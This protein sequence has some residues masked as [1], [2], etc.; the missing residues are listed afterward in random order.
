LASISPGMTDQ[1]TL[2]FSENVA[3]QKAGGA[4]IAG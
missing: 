4:A 2:H 3:V 1:T